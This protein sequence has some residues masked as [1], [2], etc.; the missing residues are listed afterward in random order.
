MDS[1]GIR[2]LAFSL[3][4]LLLFHGL[5][6]MV[7]GTGHIEK[8][9]LDMY[10]PPVEKQVPFGMWFAPFM[11]GTMFMGKMFVGKEFV[12]YLQ[13]IK[14]LSYGVYLPEVIA[15]IFLIFGRY[16]RITAFIIVLYMVVLSFLAYRTSLEILMAF[17]GWT[18]EVV[19]LYFIASM[20]L[21]FY[22]ISDCNFR[23]NKFSHKSFMK[24]LAKKTPKKPIKKKQAKNKQ[25]R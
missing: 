15:P 17:G 20:I 5:H 19:L 21:V 2:F 24:V 11:P 6:K 10:V 25:K 13:Y 23:P 14:F 22:K 9:I 8:L 7:Y 1:K 16:V 3:G 18:V 12:T 4:V